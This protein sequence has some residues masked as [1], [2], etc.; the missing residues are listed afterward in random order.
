MK[1]QKKKGALPEHKKEKPGKTYRYSGHFSKDCCT[2]LH[3]VSNQLLLTK[4]IT[5]LQL[6]KTSPKF[7]ELKNCF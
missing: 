3:A 5:L 1:R 6:F 2:L 4:S 7:V